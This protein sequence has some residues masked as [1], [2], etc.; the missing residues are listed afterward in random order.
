MDNSL[1]S[2]IILG[3]THNSLVYEIVG[4]T[5]QI[6]ELLVCLASLVLIIGLPILT[7]RLR[8]SSR[9]RRLSDDEHLLAQ[10]KLTM[11]K[12]SDDATDIVNF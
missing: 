8:K 11:G 12:A 6:Y 9:K 7:E 10:Q 4:E 2:P 5:M 1:S 3:R